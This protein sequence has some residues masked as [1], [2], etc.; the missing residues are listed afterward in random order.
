MPETVKMNFMKFMFAEISEFNL[1]HTLNN[2]RIKI[3]M[4]LFIM[5]EKLYNDVCVISILQTN[6]LLA[7]D[8]F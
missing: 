2:K 6:T 7:A 5:S 1:V 4:A 3:K 8:F